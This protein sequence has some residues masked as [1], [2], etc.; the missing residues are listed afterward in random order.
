ME[1]RAITNRPSP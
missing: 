1:E